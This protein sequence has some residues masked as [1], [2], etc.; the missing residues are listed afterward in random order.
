MTNKT[1]CHV[2][3]FFEFGMHIRFKIRFVSHEEKGFS[4]NNLLEVI[5]LQD[6]TEFK[7]RYLEENV[8]SCWKIFPFN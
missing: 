7:F 8:L 6:V 1:N 3:Q 4:Y 5:L 2:K